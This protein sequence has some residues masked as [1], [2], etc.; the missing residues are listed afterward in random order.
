[1]ISDFG[2]SGT[3]YEIGSMVRV[4]M[5]YS[6]HGQ[7]GAHC[8]SGVSASHNAGIGVRIFL[9]RTVTGKRI[10]DVFQQPHRPFRACMA[11]SVVLL[12]VE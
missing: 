9:R 8:R 10:C 2:I 3:D 11:G 7:R 12:S 6:W 5:P 4:V 1:M